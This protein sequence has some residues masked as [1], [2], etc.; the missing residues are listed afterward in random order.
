[1]KK[2]NRFYIILIAS[3]AAILLAASIIY[4]SLY[5]ENKK[6]DEAVN[7]FFDDLKN[8]KYGEDCPVFV[9]N[10]K[11]PSVLNSDQCADAMFLLEVSLMHHFFLF[12]QE[13]YDVIIEKSHFWSPIP[14]HN[15]RPVT[16]SIA[17]KAQKREVRG[18]GFS[19]KKFSEFA[20]NL[21]LL[22]RQSR[23]APVHDLLTMERKHGIWR[24]TQVNISGSAIEGIYTDLKGRLQLDRY[25]KKTPN[26]FVI[27]KMEINTKNMTPLDRMVIEYNLQK[28]AGLVDSSSSK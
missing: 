2:L 1:M 7:Y 5:G 8:K 24:V 22:T 25:V 15:A 23:I 19:S 11:G 3:V 10:S 16:I 12:K 14:E 26:G 6:V 17:L 21:F 28:I 9:E 20:K 4:I 18:K 13:N 27:E